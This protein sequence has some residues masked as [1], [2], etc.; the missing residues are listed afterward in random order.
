MDYK[1]FW[2]EEAIKDLEGIL[3]YLESRWTKK[4]IDNF[5]KKLSRQTEL[6][7]IFPRMFPVSEYNTN[8]RKAVLSKQ[9]TVF[10]KIEARVIYLVHI[11]VNHQNTDKIGD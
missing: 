11:F 4:E 5:K 2:T 7:L 8:L 6:I 10:Y 9:T 1:L 3:Q